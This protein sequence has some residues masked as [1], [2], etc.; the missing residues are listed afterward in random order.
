MNARAVPLPPQAG[1]AIVHLT[2]PQASDAPDEPPSSAADAESAE[3]AEHVRVALRAHGIDA[4]IVALDVDQVDVRLPYGLVFNLVEGTTA[5]PMAEA[6]FARS[7]A[8]QGIACTGSPARALAEALGKDRARAALAGARVPVPRGTVMWAGADA[9]SFAGP[10]FVKPARAD[11][12]YGIDEGSLVHTQAELAARVDLLVRATGGPCLVEAFLP[13]PELNVACLPTAQGGTTTSVTAIDFSPCGPDVLPIVTWDAKWTPGAPSYQCRSVPAEQLVAAG[14]IDAARVAAVR[15]FRA[16][17]LRGYGRVDLRVDASGRP[18]V[19]DVNPNCDLHPDAGFATAAR[20]VGVPWD[21]L[22]VRI[23][24]HALRHHRH[25][26]S[27]HQTARPRT[28]RRA[29]ARHVRVSR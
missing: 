29:A 28:A 22:V 16:L 4:D 3:V 18:R 24:L 23:A 10:W 11:G 20:L 17:G 5:D 6:R 8:A 1:V 15:A 25:A 14:T 9:P 7:V 27:P 13:G 19:I 26:R 12:S 21:E 2:P